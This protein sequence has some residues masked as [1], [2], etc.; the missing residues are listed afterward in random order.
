MTTTSGSSLPL[1]RFPCAFL[2]RVR[3]RSNDGL[4]DRFRIRGDA[5]L[6]FAVVAFSTLGEDARSTAVALDGEFEL[7][8]LLS[9]PALSPA[10]ELAM[11]LEQQK[12]LA[13]G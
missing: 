2:V 4:L 1:L 6:S 3:L 9:S 5:G 12:K 11:L 13:H 7:L 8:S 10:A